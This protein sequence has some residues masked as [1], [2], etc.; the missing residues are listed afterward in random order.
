[1]NEP[2]S[3]PFAVDVRPKEAV[4]RKKKVNYLT[5]SI[6]VIQ[7][8]VSRMPKRNILSCDRVTIDGVWICNWIS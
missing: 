4:E 3:P 5:V 2:L 6:A 8:R 7:N 1:M